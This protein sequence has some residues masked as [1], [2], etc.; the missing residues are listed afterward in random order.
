MVIMSCEAKEANQPFITG[1][2]IHQVGDVILDQQGFLHIIVERD[3][4][5]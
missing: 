1:I 5:L 4:L 3:A 2:P